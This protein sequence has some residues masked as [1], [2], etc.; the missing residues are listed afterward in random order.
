MTQSIPRYPTVEDYLD[1]DEPLDGR[2][3]YA[4]GEL[5]PVMPESGL[6]DL[7]ANLLMVHLA[8]KFFSF[9]LVRVHS[10][11]LEVEKFHQD[12]KQTRLP[13]L[14]VLRPEHISLTQRRLTIRKTMPSPLLVAEVVSPYPTTQH[15]NY[16]EDYIRR[17]YQ[18]AHRGIPEYW[19]IDPQA[20]LVIVRAKPF[21]GSY[22]HSSEFRQSDV[23]RSQ[24]PELNNFSLTAQEILEPDV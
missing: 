23:V 10:C 11:E 19:I 6:N 8:T 5:F 9:P 4:D 12:D 17:P 7:I 20:N 14:I 21:Q 13:D 24:L 22:R 15:K 3:E 16:Q 2:Y 18:Y 1:S